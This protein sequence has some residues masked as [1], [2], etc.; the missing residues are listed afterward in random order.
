MT[1]L[2]IRRVSGD[3]NP[4]AETE[5]AVDLEAIWKRVQELDEESPAKSRQ[6]LEGLGLETQQ[7]LK[8]YIKEVH[9]DDAVD[10]LMGCFSP[11]EALTHYM[12][13]R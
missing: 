1:V 13:Q 5:P 7:A 9:G 12:E 4:V 8:K 2:R 3:Q 6:F 11:L 10:D